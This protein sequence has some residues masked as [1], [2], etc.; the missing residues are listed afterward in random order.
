MTLDLEIEVMP[1]VKAFLRY[2]HTIAPFEVYK[3]NQYGIFLSNA[4]SHLRPVGG[5]P[6]NL[7]KYTQK[8]KVRVTEDFYSRQG[9]WIS[10]QK[11]VDFNNMV[12]YNLD[13]DFCNWMDVC[14]TMKGG[15]LQ[16]HYFS[17]REHYGLNENNFTLKCME[18]KYERH[19]K[20]LLECLSA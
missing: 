2:K 18:K 19:R 5:K 10:S 14:S 11:I 16:D 20:R 9:L 15:K 12:L 6:V 7:T 8:L 1:V 13:E 4:F 3:N 17:F